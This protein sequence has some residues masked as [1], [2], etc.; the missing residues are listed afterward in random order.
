MRGMTL[1]FSGQQRG[2]EGFTSSS[3]L[4]SQVVFLSGQRQF[5]PQREREREVTVTDRE[6]YKLE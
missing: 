2:I 1:F 6:T 3:I 5:A 4:R